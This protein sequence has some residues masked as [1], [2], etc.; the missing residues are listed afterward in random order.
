MP[1][2]VT[3]ILV[4]TLSGCAGQNE[5]TK[6]LHQMQASYAEGRLQEYTNKADEIISEI[7]NKNLVYLLEM[8]GPAATIELGEDGLK[9]YYEN[10][11]FVHLHRNSGFTSS[12]APELTFDEHD[13]VGYAFFYHF[14]SEN[15]SAIFKVVV[16]SYSEQLLIRGMSFKNIT[17]RSS[18]F[19]QQAGSTGRL[20]ASL[21]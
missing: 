13:N 16:I 11:I 18:S 21:N 10:E 12:G 6:I 2:I 15:S 7:Q 3:L 1:R 4:L 8:T 19:H 17:N 5:M 20:T 14:E 9:K